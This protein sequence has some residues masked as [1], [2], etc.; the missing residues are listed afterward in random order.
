MISHAAAEPHTQPTFR[1]YLYLI[2][3]WWWLIVAAAA[4]GLVLALM[5]SVTAA[6]VYR[7]S[8]RIVVGRSASTQLGLLPDITG[9]SQN[10]YV[11]T[12]ANIIQSRA[13]AEIA[14][15]RLR[16]PPAGRARVIRGLRSGLEV[17]RLRA[18]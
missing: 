11:E 15:T 5:L 10:T 8:T 9:T 6:P 16:V 2:Q 7:G 14:A 18:T 12:L 17:T 4:A 3:R 1:E 13:V